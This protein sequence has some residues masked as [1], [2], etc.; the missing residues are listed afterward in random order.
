MD[1]RRASSGRPPSVGRTSRLLLLLDDD[2]AGCIGLNGPGG[3]IS[4]VY[5]PCVL[6]CVLCGTIKCRDRS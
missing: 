4:G 3:F 2:D 6:M 5:C 1:G